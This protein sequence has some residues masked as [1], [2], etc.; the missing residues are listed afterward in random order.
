MFSRICSLGAVLVGVLAGPALGQDNTTARW[1]QVGAWQVSV[2]ADRGCMV[3]TK[4]ADGTILGLG[5]DPLRKTVYLGL[6]NATWRSLQ[7]GRAYP[8]R[9]VFDGLQSYDG[10]LMA[11]ADNEGVLLIHSQVSP[12][13]IKDFAQRTTVRLYYRG[14]QVS[15][16][17]LRDTYA[18]LTEVARC[19]HEMLA[20]GGGN[21][22][23]R[24]A[25]DPFSR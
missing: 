8:M 19:Q 18:A 5:I 1:G 15:H 25:G 2:N 17:S 9:F 14:L 10:E 16:L 23:M 13:F 21:R 4:Y 7:A 3:T 22:D 20:A 11:V 6:G 12:E 24:V